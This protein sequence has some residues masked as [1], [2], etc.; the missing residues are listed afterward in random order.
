MVWIVE[1]D[2]LVRLLSELVERKVSY[3]I[4]CSCF[5]PQV[6]SEY[7]FDCEDARQLAS[8]VKLL[9]DF[10]VNTCIIELKRNEDNGKPN[11]IFLAGENVFVV[12]NIPGEVLSKL[13]EKFEIAVS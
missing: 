6:G 3:V 9:H 13:I 12:S 10:D 1:K 11:V 8:L 7:Y 4:F 2:K 5:F